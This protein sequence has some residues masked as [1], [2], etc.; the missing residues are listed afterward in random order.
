[1]CC[2]ERAAD[3]SGKS[4]GAVGEREWEKGYLGKLLHKCDIPTDKWGL[5]GNGAFRQSE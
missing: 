1:V 5:S 4:E 2:T 3:E